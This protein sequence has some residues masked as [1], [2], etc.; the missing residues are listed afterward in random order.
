MNRP[1]SSRISRRR[2]L[3]AGL[4]V[5]TVLLPASSAALTLLYFN[6]IHEI[7]PVDGGLRGGMARV[8]GLVATERAGE[9]HVLV[10]IG[11]DLAGGTLFGLMRGEPMIKALNLIGVDAASFGQHEFDHGVTQARRLV[12]LSEFPW[13]SANLTE[14]DGAPF[15]GLERYRVLEVDGTRVGVFGITT[16]MDTTRH[17]GQVVEQDVVASARSAVAALQAAEVD[18]IVALTQQ[19][20]AEDLAMVRAV[21]GI[22]LVLGEEVSET[23]S[24]IDF[25]GGTYLARSAGN[26]SSLIRAQ[27]LGP[28]ASDWRLSV[29]PVDAHAP[30]DPAVARLSDDY[31]AKLAEQLAAPVRAVDQPWQLMRDKARSEET[32]LGQLVA[33]A[34]R[35]AMASDVGFSSAGGLR[36][37][38]RAQPPALSLAD[39]AAVLPFDNRLVRLQISGAEL[40]ELMEL[41]LAEHPVARNRFPLI[42]GLTV[43]FDPEAPPG[44]RVRSLN[45]N[46]TAIEPDQRL[47]LAT[48]LFLAGGGDGYTLLRSLP[49]E[50]VGALDREALA[51][52]LAEVDAWPPAP[53]PDPALIAP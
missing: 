7:A 44:Q 28:G 6:D 52:W 25:E 47:T 16:A 53:E 29:I 32:A 42:S 3:I 39:V 27:W 2:C 12:E 35:Q 23:R 22:D 4:L 38:L 30:E 36:A 24:Q 41:A 10:L 17:E 1:Q 21:P 50:S 34:F 26:V 15:H 13:V 37:D 5:L 51:S 45:R 31:S 40:R 18:L 43:D 9:D 19:T 33:E 8:A 14:V 11:G 48:S 46:G 49:R 20:P